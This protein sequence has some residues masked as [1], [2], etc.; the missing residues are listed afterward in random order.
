MLK[1]CKVISLSLLLFAFQSN[2]T[3]IIYGFSSGILPSETQEFVYRGF[4][5][6]LTNF[7]NI[8]PELDLKLIY[9]NTGGLT[10]PVEVAR[11][12]LKEKPQ[13]I[14]GFPSSFESQLVAPIFK[15]SGILTIFASSSNLSLDKMASNIYSSSE[16]ILSANSNIAK[17][18][19]SKH[20]NELGA[21]IYN[22]FDYF[23]VNQ[24]STWKII[25]NR[26][27][28]LKIKLLPTAADGKIPGALLKEIKSFKFVI[29]TLFPSKSYEFFR[30][31]DENNIDIPIYTNSSWY[32]MEF[33]LLKR[34]LSNKKS[35]V[36]QV[37]FKEFDKT[38]ESKIIKN[39]REKYKSIPAP[40]VFV[41]YDLGIIIGTIYRK[42]RDLKTDPSKIMHSGMC[43]EG[44]P[45][46]KVCFNGGGGFANRD[47][48][49]VNINEKK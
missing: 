47:V 3:P 36:Y 27:P 10:A 34:F 9:S 26:S 16:S 6:G 40:E 5:L 28:G 31:F 43:F 8:N 24:Q 13:I 29:T 18:I 25:L 14:T 42:S 23:S 7:K 45:F 33:T 48:S 4:L 46:G 2:A 37:K 11:D 22:P 44:S 21:L 12:V 38:I 17:Q 35:A 49:L 30:F 1:L 20:K 19:E 39:Y 41:G 15:E 32:K